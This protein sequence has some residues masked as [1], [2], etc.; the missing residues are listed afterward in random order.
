M[1]FISGAAVAALLGLM[2]AAGPTFLMSATWAPAAT[3]LGTGA[4]AGSFATF[5]QA[6]SLL[7]ALAGAALLWQARPDFGSK[8]GMAIVLAAVILS[9]FVP[10]LGPALLLLAAAWVADR[11]ATLILAVFASLWIIGAFYYWLGWPMQQKAMLLVALGFGIGAV[12]LATGP[13]LPKTPRAAVPATAMPGLVAAALILTSAAATGGLTAKG[14]GEKEAII[15]GGRRVFVALAPVD[16]RSLMQGDYMALRFALPDVSKAPSPQS[17][18][19][20]Y[21]V[22]TIDGRGVVTL[23]GASP[24]LPS[25][26]DDRIAFVLGVKNGRWLLGTDAW[27]FKE[28]TAQS[29]GAARFGE[30]RVTRD[31]QA[32]LVG[33]ADEQLKGLK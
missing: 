3:R 26:A 30:F 18:A 19:T 8:A 6:G 11:K 7:C 15:T 28:G 23:T 4:E 14:I 9:V 21:A 5:A 10:A 29:W 2:A 1:P 17:G 25:P 32:I 24:T 22:G 16:P 27:F 20:L 31:G 13:G 33:M 12:A